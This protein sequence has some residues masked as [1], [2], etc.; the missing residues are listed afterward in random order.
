[1]P[2]RR[3][4]QMFAVTQLKVMQECITL[5][6]FTV[7]AYLMFGESLRWNNFVSYG[8]IIGA[9]YFSFRFSPS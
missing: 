2:A 3:G 1:V 4:V 6:V 5:V 9:V 8:L 7:I